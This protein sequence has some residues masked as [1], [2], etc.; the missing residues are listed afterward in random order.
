MHWHFPSEKWTALQKELSLPKPTQH[1]C[2]PRSILSGAEISLAQTS[3]R[4]YFQFTVQFLLNVKETWIYLEMGIFSLK[5]C[6]YPERNCL[7]VMWEWWIAR[8][9]LPLADAYT[10][11]TSIAKQWVMWLVG[12]RNVSFQ[13]FGSAPCTSEALN[14]PK[15]SHY[16]GL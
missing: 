14:S 8:L 1:V 16:F 4:F 10:R 2:K 3:E 7:A 15:N 6:V 12:R 13:S 11:A 5:P 9:V